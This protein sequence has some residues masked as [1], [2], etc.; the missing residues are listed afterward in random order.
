MADAQKGI[1]ERYTVVI[2]SL[3]YKG[4]E[5]GDVPIIWWNQ[6]RDGPGRGGPENIYVKSSRAVAHEFGFENI[7][8]K[9]EA[10]LNQFDLDINGMP[11]PEDAI[12][13]CEDL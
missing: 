3:T 13:E 10:L 11:I 2:K 1:K 4:Y 9:F 7:E 8:E 12:I 5:I 6:N